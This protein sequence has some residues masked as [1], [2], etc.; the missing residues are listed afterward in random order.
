MDESLVLMLDGLTPAQLDALL[1]AETDLPKADP[2][3]AARVAA[4]V[5]GRAG[6]E[7]GAA[8]PAG[9]GPAPEAGAPLG[10]A[11][12]AG[13]GAPAGKAPRLGV[14]RRRL[15]GLAAAL[16]LVVLAGALVARF[17]LGGSVGT[18][19]KQGAAN[20]AAA[21]A[22]A[23]NAPAAGGAAPAD[24]MPEMEN[25]LAEAGP[26]A[27]IPEGGVYLPPVELPETMPGETA[28]MDMIGLVVYQGRVYTQAQDLYLASEADQQALL[29]DYLGQASGTI[30]EWSTQSDYATE[31]AA[32]ISGPVYAA[33]GYD[34][35]FRIAV[36]QTFTEEGLNVT[37]EGGK[38][39]TVYAVFY[40]ECLSDVTL[41]N[42][43]ALYADRLHLPGNITAITAQSHADW[44][45]ARQNCAPLALGDEAVDAF[46]QAL[47]AAPLEE[48]TGAGA[49]Q[50]LYDQP[51]VHV[52]LE[53]ADGTTVALR[54][55]EGGY[56]RYQYMTAH[57]FAKMDGPAFDDFYAAC[58]AAVGG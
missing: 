52:Y 30:D 2:A 36:A 10:R 15:P 46:V 31:L 47:C 24:G 49:R 19:A 5:M 21:M 32:N 37:G 25:A 23:E 45:N 22:P 16:A 39:G 58:L 56:V 53:M 28:A 54:L 6:L 35:A 34:R 14:W 29:G 7:A 8:A 41:A 1:P 3:Q 44:D 51:Q 50:T 38:G 40:Y 33:K 57:V 27:G 18:S 48:H 4:L 26:D 20:S 11:G 9:T 13:A 43:G 12:T 17:G 42:G 55:I